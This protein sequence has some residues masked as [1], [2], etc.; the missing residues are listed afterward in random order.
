[1]DIIYNVQRIGDNKLLF[2]YTLDND[3][4]V[5]VG[6]LTNPWTKISK[7]AATITHEGTD[8]EWILNII[9][10]VQ[11]YEDLSSGQVFFN[12]IGTWK[13]TI[14]VAGV[15]IDTIDLQVV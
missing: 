3:L 4:P 2:N 14:S 6:V 5:F 10:I 15:L 11:A 8:G 1:M 12:N 7:T 9:G 13:T